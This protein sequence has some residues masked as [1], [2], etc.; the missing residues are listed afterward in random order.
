MV[1]ILNNS[2]TCEI[3]TNNFHE[4]FYK[5]TKKSWMLAN[6][7]KNSKFYDKANKKV[8]GKIKDETKGI[9]IVG[10]IGLKFKMY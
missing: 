6:I 10:F 9:P 8:M 7:E 5:K 4:G 3:E 2:L 1:I